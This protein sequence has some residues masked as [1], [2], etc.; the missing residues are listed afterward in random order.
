M[1]VVLYAVLDTHYITIKDDWLVQIKNK[2]CGEYIEG[3][4]QILSLVELGEVNAFFGAYCG[5]LLSAKYMPKSLAEKKKIYALWRFLLSA[6][7]SV[8]LPLVM[9]LTI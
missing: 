2:G 8:P 7:I 4:F 9:I 6:V 1:T 5:L 3:G